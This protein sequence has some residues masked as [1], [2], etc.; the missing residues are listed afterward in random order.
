MKRS[1]R[2]AKVNL[3]PADVKATSLIEQEQLWWSDEDIFGV[4]RESQ[5]PDVQIWDSD[6]RETEREIRRGFAAAIKAGSEEKIN[7]PHSRIRGKTPLNIHETK[8]RTSIEFWGAR[9]F[10]LTAKTFTP[11]EIIYTLARAFSSALSKCMKGQSS[12]VEI[13][14]FCLLFCSKLIPSYGNDTLALSY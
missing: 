1:S 12:F 8:A 13:T 14:W 10:S 5:P 11:I 7:A 6:Q 2:C 4:E 3:S 9:T